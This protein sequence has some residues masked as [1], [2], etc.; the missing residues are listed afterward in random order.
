[1]V[2][3]GGTLDLGGLSEGFGR[4]DGYGG[5]VTNSVAA[6]TSTLFVGTASISN[7]FTA[8]FYGSVQNGAGTVALGKVGNGIAIFAGDLLHTGG[9]NIYAGALQIGN[10]GATGTIGGNIT[11][12]NASTASLIIN[13]GGTALIP[14]NISGGGPVIS[15]GSGLVKLTG[16]NTYTGT[17]TINDGILQIGDAG[18]TGTLGTGNVT[19]YS[20]L[21]FK[22]TDA[23]T[24]SNA[25]TGPGSVNQEGTGTTTLNG[26]LDFPVAN[27][28][29]GRLNLDSVLANAT[30]NDNNGI[31]VVNANAN[32]STVN[33]ADE[34]YFTVNQTLAALNITGGGVA[35]LGAAP[36]SSPSDAPQEADLPVIG[37]QSP[38]A[39]LADGGVQAVPEPGAMGLLLF[40]VL[41][42]LGRRRPAPKS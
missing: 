28:N 29:D 10:G 5:I 14:A 13:R 7:L 39:V 9:T 27:I 12:V 24:V 19:L 8:G 38:A 11:L 36:P 30:I 16:A 17:T 3:N 4:L 33:V 20:T 26:A 15:N 23:L 35:T 32:N 22:R 1:M 18:T 41:G 21:A 25:I 6:T 42:L 31:L 37:M 40:G 2:I 34:T